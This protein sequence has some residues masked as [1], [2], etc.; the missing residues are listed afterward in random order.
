MPGSRRM[1]PLGSIGQC[2]IVV[3]VSMNLADKK[4][5]EAVGQRIR[6]RR[7]AQKLTLVQLAKMVDLDRTYLGLLET[8]EKNI[9]LLNLRRLAQKLRM[10]LSDIVAELK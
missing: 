4:F 8:G 7:K 6:E 1:R 10:P 5:L 9:S 2:I 3:K